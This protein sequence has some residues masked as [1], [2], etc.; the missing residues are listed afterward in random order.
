MGGNS[1]D[2]DLEK[3]VRTPPEIRDTADSQSSDLLPE[4]QRDC[5]LIYTTY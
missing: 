5:T 3:Y 2:S 1:S 4:N